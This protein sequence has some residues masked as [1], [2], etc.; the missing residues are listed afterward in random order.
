MEGQNT[1][2]STTSFI[3]A[4]GLISGSTISTP[5]F[6]A[7]T[8]GLT[9]TTVSATT[10]YNLPV[11]GLTQGSNITITNNGSGNYTISSTGG[12][13][14]GVTTTG[15]TYSYGT[16]TFTNSTGG[17]FNVTGFTKYFVTGSTPTGYTLVDGD[18]WF[19]TN[20]GLELVWITD[21]DGSQW[22]Q[23]TQGGGG[24][25]TSNFL[26]LSGGTVTGGTIF[27]AGL[28]ANTIS[29]TTYQN[30]PFSGTV[31]GTGTSN[32]VT[33]W[34]NGIDISD[35][36]IYDDGSFVGINTTVPIY[37]E[38][39]SFQT[40]NRGITIDSLY[41]QEN[42]NG[43]LAFATGFD[44]N[45][46]GTG[47]GEIAIG[48]RG[49]L[50]NSTGSGN[51]GI[52]DKALN[53]NT[54]GIDNLAIGGTGALANNLTGGDNIA[55]GRNSLFFNDDGLQ[56]VAI[57]NGTLYNNITG[58]RN[59]VLGNQAGYSNLSD[60]NVY[61]GHGAGYSNDG[62][63]NIF[64]GYSAGGSDT[65]SSNKLNIGD[66]IIGDLSAKSISVPTISATTYQNLPSQSGTGVSSLSFIPTT[67]ILTLTKNDTTTLTTGTFTYLS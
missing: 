15:G 58:D 12:G 44:Y 23:P 25:S 14:G 6:T 7:N 39:I 38:P 24:S 66:T 56:N 18:R 47:G 10:Y 50:E 40:S 55:I 42:S 52:G 9:A 46:W 3:R 45:S 1:A 16:A 32:Y 26:P 67:G 61:I 48:T 30:L 35:S 37:S 28:T 43:S 63:N 33:K 49:P 29:A 27:T 8:N 2:G 41:I 22:V 64:I 51:I 5:G 17:T 31:G 11:S 36:V 34:S 60:Y 62:S 4:D 20:S 54:S 13:G 19:D 59:T 21:G 57:G 65:S 53:A